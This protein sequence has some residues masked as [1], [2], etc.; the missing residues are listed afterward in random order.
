MVPV[1]AY[2]DGSAPPFLGAVGFGVTRAA[3]GERGR[4]QH[5]ITGYPPQITRSLVVGGRLFRLS[6]AGLLASGLDTL[7]PGPWVPFPDGPGQR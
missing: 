4:V 1:S 3:I 2:G 7:Q 5:P 6:D